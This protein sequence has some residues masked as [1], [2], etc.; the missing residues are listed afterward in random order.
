[1]VNYFRCYSFRFLGF[2]R[3]IEG[4]KL[5]LLDVSHMSRKRMAAPRAT[6]LKQIDPG[7]GYSLAIFTYV[8]FGCQRGHKKD[9]RR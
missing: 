2:N 9:I 5:M 4:F 8:N 3:N 1:M 6:H 7:V